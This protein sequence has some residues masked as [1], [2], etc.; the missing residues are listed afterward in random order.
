M[1]NH[2]KEKY[3]HSTH[4]SLTTINYCQLEIEYNNKRNWISFI[5][6]TADYSDIL[7]DRIDLYLTLLLFRIEEV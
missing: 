1:V 2:V 7:P 6:I 4:D 3:L 5:M